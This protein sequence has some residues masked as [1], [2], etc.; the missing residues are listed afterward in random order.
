MDM[1]EKIMTIVKETKTLAVIAALA[2]LLVL[3]LYEISSDKTSG[4]ILHYVAPLFY[5]IL[6]G[7]YGMIASWFAIRDK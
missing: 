7:A 5:V 6:A 3:L 4:Y 1:L 2:S